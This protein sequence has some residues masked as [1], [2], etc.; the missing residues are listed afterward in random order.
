MQHKNSSDERERRDTSEHYIEELLAQSMCQSLALN[1]YGRVYAVGRECPTWP[2]DGTNCNDICSHSSLH[3][4][5]Q[6]VHNTWSC[7]GAYHVYYDRPATRRNGD[8]HSAT[9][10]LKS[11]Q[12]LCF[13][14]KCGPNFCCCFAVPD[15]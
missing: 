14:R 15:S 8:I 2:R 11:L 1:R 12:Q 5:V 3:S 6:T 4:D 9:L 7:I 10:G 13:Y